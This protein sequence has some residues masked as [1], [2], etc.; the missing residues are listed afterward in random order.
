MF[1]FGVTR[2]AR[3]AR[4][5]WCAAAGRATRKKK[6]IGTEWTLAGLV[7]RAD[8]NGAVVRVKS[9]K[10]DRFVVLRLDSDD[11][12]LV[13]PKH[14][15]SV[16]DPS[17]TGDKLTEAV[18]HLQDSTADER[19]RRV[20]ELFTTGQHEKALR[21]AGEWTLAKV[22]AIPMGEGDERRDAT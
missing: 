15:V 3:E 7:R 22:K 17:V 2:C 12:I 20:A 19:L 18:A 11:N 4:Q 13:H 9:V 8:L 5:S 16:Q 1:P 10:G 21:V 6:M 14:L